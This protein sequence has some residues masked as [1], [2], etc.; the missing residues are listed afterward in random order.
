MFRSARRHQSV[1][2]TRIRK[3]HGIRTFRKVGN[4]LPE[5]D[6]C[7]EVLC[8]VWRN[9]VSVI[10]VRCRIFHYSKKKPGAVGDQHTGDQMCLTLRMIWITVAS[11]SLTSP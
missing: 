10:L 6:G 11:A 7:A 8:R 4:V 9:R 1:Y 3:R 5:K 2:P